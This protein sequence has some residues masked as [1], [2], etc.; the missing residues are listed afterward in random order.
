MILVKNEDG[1]YTATG[2]DTLLS[3]VVDGLKAP[4]LA[5]NEYLPSKAAFWGTAAYAVGTAAASSIIARK[6][7]SEG[8]APMAKVFF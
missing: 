1:S 3:N 7:Q 8:K 2:E 4:F 5:E 6:R